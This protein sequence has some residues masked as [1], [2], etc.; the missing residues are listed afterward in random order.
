M[1]KCNTSHDTRFEDSIANK[2]IYSY[3]KN[4]QTHLDIFVAALATLSSSALCSSSL[5]VSRQDDGDH[6]GRRSAVEE[7]S[8]DSADRIVVLVAHL[9]PVGKEISG[10]TKA[11][12]KRDACD[13]EDDA[14][15]KARMAADGA[16]PFMVVVLGTLAL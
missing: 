4:K 9:V 10:R 3:V 12:A 13:G 16:D 2:Q 1:R 7:D 6:S 11:D 14:V 15:A 8:A 5:I